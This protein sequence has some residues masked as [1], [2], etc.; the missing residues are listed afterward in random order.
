LEK[1]T[2][3]FERQRKTLAPLLVGGTVKALEVQAKQAFW[4][5]TADTLSEGLYLRVPNSPSLYSLGLPR[6]PA[7]RPLSKP[8]CSIGKSA[9]G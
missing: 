2:V 1:S 4:L 3:E 6:R 7:W 5:G 9:S 8:C